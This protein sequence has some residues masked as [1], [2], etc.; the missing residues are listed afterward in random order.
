MKFDEETITF[1]ASEN[2]ETSNSA[3]NR[4]E[5]T[6]DPRRLENAAAAGINVDK[7]TNKKK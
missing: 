3:H 5:G 1:E 7:L 6:A 4:T 2:R